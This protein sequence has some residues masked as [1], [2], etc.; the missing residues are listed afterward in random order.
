VEIGEALEVCQKSFWEGGIRS[1]IPENDIEQLDGHEVQHD[2]APFIDFL[3]TSKGSKDGY[4]R[5]THASAGVFLRGLAKKTV[6]AA[7]VLQISSNVIAEVC[8]TYLSQTRYRD[9]KLDTVRTHRF[10]SYA[11]K[12][13]QRHMDEADSDPILLQVASDFIQSVQFLTM[14]RFQ[15]C[16][17]NRHFNTRP[18]SRPRGDESSLT[19]RSI[20]QSVSVKSSMPHIVDD[21]KHF[22][23]EWGEALQIGTTHCAPGDI[24]GNCFWGALGKQ[25]ALRRQGLETERNKSFLLEIDDVNRNTRQDVDI[26]MRNCFYETISEDGGRVAVWQMPAPRYDCCPFRSPRYFKYHA[27]T[28]YSANAIDAGL[29]DR[30]KLFRASWYID[31]HMTPFRCGTQE[32]LEIKTK[33]CRL[34]TFRRG[35]FSLITDWETT[36]HVPTIDESNYG[37]VVRVGSC[38]FHRENERHWGARYVSNDKSAA[39]WDSVEFRDPWAIYSHRKQVCLSEE[40]KGPNQISESGKDHDIP[41][42]EVADLQED[43]DPKFGPGSDDDEDSVKI[44]PKPASDDNGGS[45]S[46]SSQTTSAVSEGESESELEDSKTDTLSALDDSLSSAEEFCVDS[47]SDQG[48][49]G[50]SSSDD[51]WTSDEEESVSD[52]AEDDDDEDDEIMEDNNDATSLISEPIDNHTMMMSTEASD[53]DD[54]SGSGS[55]VKSSR[56]RDGYRKHSS[57]SGSLIC[58]RCGATITHNYIPV[59]TKLDTYYQCIFCANNNSFD[60]CSTCFGK[61]AWCKDSSHLLSQCLFSARRRLWKD[62]I[63]QHTAMPLIKIAA[64]YKEGGSESAERHSIVP[65]FGYNRRHTVMLH[66]SKPIIHPRLPLL[67]YP[68]DGRKLLFSNLKKNTY[69]MHDIPFETSETAETSGGTCIPISVNLRFS[70]CGKFF[71]MLRV[72]ARNDSLIGPI[73]INVVIMKIA[74]SSKDPCSG[75]PTTLPDCQSSNLGTWPRFVS[76]LPYA[77]TWTEVH[78]YVSMSDSFLN[79]FRFP[80][81]VDEPTTTHSEYITNRVCTFSRKI[82]L[83]RSS[84]SRSVKFFPSNNNASAKIILGSAHGKEPEPPIIVYLETDQPSEW[85]PT[86]QRLDWTPR[87]NRV[88]E[89]ALIEEPYWDEDVDLVP[90]PTAGGEWHI[91]EPVLRYRELLLRGFQTLGIYCSSCFE[92]GIKLDFLRPTPKVP[93]HYVGQARLAN[94]KA[95]LAWSVPVQAMVE[96]LQKGC[97]FCCYVALRTLKFNHIRYT[98]Q[99]VGRGGVR[100]CAKGSITENPQDIQE[101][102]DYINRLK[103]DVPREKQKFVFRCEAQHWDLENRSFDKLLITL[104]GARSGGELGSHEFAPLVATIKGENEFGETL[105]RTAFFH[106]PEFPRPTD[107]ECA[108]ELHATSSKFTHDT[109]SI[110][111]SKFPY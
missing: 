28:I 48:P 107:P 44:E 19:S 87:S 39:R 23:D 29:D 63:S 24:I 17:L 43:G 41:P 55:S 56:R 97:P 91:I 59:D 46:Q 22:I 98:S 109:R 9:A 21:Y 33:S 84:R 8:L 83:P 15:S 7:G 14:T 36:A 99:S 80:L 65:S 47:L 53:T 37:A 73:D 79:V 108:L 27:D 42:P 104:L 11:A 20:P 103:W 101:V 52:N 70:P 50:A 10:Y 100:C 82:A 61:G 102:M 85:I 67:V 95:N 34:E 35:D 106:D 13:W 77:I 76:R 6:T 4:L 3:P 2:C 92:L 81:H 93:V 90:E 12:Y 16:F 25:N 60:I 110:T 69:F 54:E 58:D 5:L 45:K 88:R 26:S 51:S 68:L 89:D 31:G 94:S 64:G 1:L 38:L 75:K 40:K 30:C 78:A 86:A 96:A 71:H 74:L 105:T 57:P 111:T 62:G 32:M 18:T 66:D 72:T 49:S